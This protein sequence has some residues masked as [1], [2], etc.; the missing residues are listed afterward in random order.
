MFIEDYVKIGHFKLSSGRHSSDYFQTA[1]ALATYQTAFIDAKC[2]LDKDEFKDK[3]YRLV[4]CAAV[5]G[6]IIANAFAHLCGASMI[7]AERVDGKLQFRRGFEQIINYYIEDL[8][9]ECNPNRILL[10]EDVITTGK[11]TKELINLIRS[12]NLDCDNID[13]ACLI[14]RTN[15]Q[16][17]LDIISMYQISNETFD[18]DN[19]LLCD[20]GLPLDIPGSRF[21]K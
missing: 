13:T 17:G 18:P 7:F 15:G 6:I 10:I 5:G 16:S 11:T 1:P 20:E 3:D 21:I 12:Y 9:N 4:I 2:M 14:D 8:K 19:C